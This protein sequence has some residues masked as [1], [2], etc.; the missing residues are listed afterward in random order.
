MARAAKKTRTRARSAQIAT[1]RSGAKNGAAKKRAAS[2]TRSVQQQ[3]GP[4]TSWLGAVTTLAA[5]P[6]GRIIL[7]DALDAAAATIRN[8]PQLITE[9]V[10]ASMEAASNAAEVTVEAVQEAAAALADMATRVIPA[11]V[12]GPEVPE[13]G[14]GRR[15]GRKG[16]AKKRR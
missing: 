5:S 3:G 13:Q 6:L 15:S 4:S 1:K 12:G 2:K 9:A 10:D 11:F 14:N 7:A 16:G 8:R